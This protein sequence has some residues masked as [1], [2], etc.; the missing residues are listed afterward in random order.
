MDLVTREYQGQ[1][2]T[3]QDDGWFNATQAA[4]KFGKRIDHWMDNQ[5]T[6]DYIS[7]VCAIS[8]T[9]V[10]GYLKTK[11]GNSGGT[12]LHPKLAVA[13]ARWLD[14]NFAVWCDAQIDELI[15]GKAGKIEL[16]HDAAVSYKIMSDMLT[17]TREDQ[18]KETKFFHYSN[19]ALL[20]NEVLT[21]VREK[22]DRNALD[23]ISLDLL[24]RL[25]QRN[26]A[27]IAMNKDTNSRRAS[28]MAFRNQW[29]SKRSLTIGT[30]H[31]LER[32]A[33]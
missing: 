16:R 4:G 3:Y 13:F 25:E 31:Q 2:I 21:G 24:A 1:S 8:N 27:L 12:W 23:K 26:T 15:H 28:L 32:L 11:R 9:P 20:I 30:N 17:M 33:A 7:A 18:G 5:E 6:K 22:I 19:E 14:P 29:L 10:S